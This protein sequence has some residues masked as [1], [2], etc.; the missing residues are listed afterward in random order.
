MM[1]L[2]SALYN[3]NAWHEVTASR[4]MFGVAGRLAV[5]GEVVDAPMGLV[6]SSLSSLGSCAALWVWWLCFNRFAVVCF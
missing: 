5:D 6:S 2:T 4:N 1:I 3:D